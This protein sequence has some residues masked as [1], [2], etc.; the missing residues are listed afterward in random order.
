[1][2]QQLTALMAPF[3]ICAVKMVTCASVGARPL[4]GERS[5]PVPVK[6]M[7][8]RDI[9][10]LHKLQHWR[11][12]SGIYRLECPSNGD[13]QL[14]VRRIADNFMSSEENSRLRHFRIVGNPS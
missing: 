14:V 2:N 13:V 6:H 8:A 12:V 4:P 10:F 1:M 11:G 5:Y 9:I 3:F 7:K